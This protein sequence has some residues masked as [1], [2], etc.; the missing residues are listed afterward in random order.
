MF[1]KLA[2]KIAEK[3][4][5]LTREPQTADPSRF[6][7]P[8][9]LQTS[10]KPAK[11]GGTNF[12]TH[13][14]VVVS[15][16]R[17]EFRSSL[18]GKLF[19]L[20]FLLT[21]LGILIGFPAYRIIHGTSLLNF[22]TAFLVMFGLVFSTVGGLMLYF[23]TMPSVFDKRWE[24]FCKGRK[25]PEMVYDK[26]RLKHYAKL[27]DIHALQLIS[28]YCRGDKSSYYSYELNLVLEDG[29]R[30]NV[31]D[32]GDKKKLQADA[33]TLADFLTVPVWDAI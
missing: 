8:L 10:W 14:L 20:V 1:N 7:D 29:S 4:Q 17:L 6:D 11:G 27:D 32:H 13:R 33:N 3:L 19:C 28:E 18:G 21:G 12:R 9:A 5:K 30:I 22:E 15:T 26:R 31:V 24:Y 25:N 23:F 16:Q 2:E